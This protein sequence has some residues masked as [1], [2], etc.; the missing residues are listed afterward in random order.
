MHSGDMV[1]SNAGHNPPQ[2]RR[3]CGTLESLEQ[4]SGVMLGIMD[5]WTFD[6]AQLQ[7]MPGDS[8]L[9]YSDGVSEAQD[10]AQT[11]FGQTRLAD[12]FA[13]AHQD[14]QTG[15]TQLLAS[16][17]AFAGQA[18]QFDDITILILRFK[19]QNY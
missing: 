4:A 6:T 10:T 5:E 17:D 2:L 12:S 19:P 8:L 18:E 7:L 13:Q 14:A 15:V 9:L 1:Y 3:S 11:L 16:V